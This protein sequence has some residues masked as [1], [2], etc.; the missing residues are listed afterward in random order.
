MIG[1]R[2]ITMTMSC[3]NTKYMTKTHQEIKRKN[4]TELLLWF[5]AKIQSSDNLTI[6]YRFSG[7]DQEEKESLFPQFCG[8]DTE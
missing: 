4:I 3:D 7:S 6:F 5:R 1:T 2:T 8:V